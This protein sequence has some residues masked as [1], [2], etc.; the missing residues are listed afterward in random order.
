MREALAKKANHWGQGAR[1]YA[2]PASLCFV[3]RQA[4]KDHHRDSDQ[5][6][7]PVNNRGRTYG[8]H[9]VRAQTV[10]TQTKYARTHTY[11]KVQKKET[12]GVM[13]EFTGLSS[14]TK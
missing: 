11:P 13:F 14:R 2:S 4:V 3:H 8:S 1:Q 6:S 12:E 5:E 9:R 10:R 7:S